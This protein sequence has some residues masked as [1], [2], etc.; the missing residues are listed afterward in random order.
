MGRSWRERLEDD[1]GF[2]RVV[3]IPEKMKRQWGDGTVVI[4]APREVDEMMRRVPKGKVITI[5]GIREI[6]AR[7]HN[8]SICCPMV[9][10]IFACIAARAAEEARRGGEEEVTPYWRTLKEGG[11]VNEKYPGGA[12]AQKNLLESEGHKVIKRG[13]KFV[14]VDFQRYLVEI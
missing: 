7:R 3:E 13:K 12:E 8:A 11:I 10:G 2:P 14:V 9:T 1:K 5:N 6:L 4:P